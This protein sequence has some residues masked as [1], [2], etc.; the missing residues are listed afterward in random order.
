MPIQA[1]ASS[2]LTSVSRT[3]LLPFLY[4]SAAR[5]STFVAIKTPAVRRLAST[6]SKTTLRPASSSLLPRSTVTSAQS[7]A[8]W[9]STSSTRLTPASSSK[10]QSA[11]YPSTS[12]SSSHSTP[13]FPSTASSSSS[14]LSHS[15]NPETASIDPACATL[16]PS[17]PASPKSQ[18]D[19]RVD[20]APEQP[21]PTPSP[22]TPAPSAS[23]PA[24]QVLYICR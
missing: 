15:N 12:A 23:A 3:T 13:P 18:K 9:L 6:A 1:S 19:P 5:C 10:S 17:S 7:S 20:A 24:P 16:S 4:P 2:T 21:A 8:R 11:A 22:A 14:K